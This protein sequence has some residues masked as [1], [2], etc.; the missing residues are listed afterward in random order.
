MLAM[1]G[2]RVTP[3]MPTPPEKLRVRKTLEMQAMRRADIDLTVIVFLFLLLFVLCAC[4]TV[5]IYV[6]REEDV[7]V[8]FWPAGVRIEAM[9]GARGLRVASDALGLSIG[10]GSIGLGISHTDCIQID[11][12]TCGLAIFEG[13]KDREALIEAGRQTFAHCQ[14]D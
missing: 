12:D 6:E 4:S 7:R 10:C 2:M 8:S 5:N 3:A 14:G 13:V 11:P 1:P 9:E